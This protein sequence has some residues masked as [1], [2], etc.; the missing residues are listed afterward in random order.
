MKQGNVYTVLFAAAVCGV[1]SIAVCVSSV[2][3]KDL[4]EQNKIIDRQKNV[5]RVAGL[6]SEKEELDPDQV[7]A[8]FNKNIEARVL[9]LESGEY[10]SS[11]DV[12]TYDQRKALSDPNMSRP[13]PENPARII[14]LPNYALI[15][16]V[17]EK[18]Q[19]KSIVLPMEGKGLWSTMY[20][21][22]ALA[23]NTNT[24]LGITFYE[25][26]ETPGLGGE[27]DNP[28]WKKLWVGRRAFD[29][30]W[31]PKISVIKGLA[32]KPEIDPYRVDGISGATLTARGVSDLVQFWLG[33]HGFG[34]FLKKFRAKGGV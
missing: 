5:L 10:V 30:T 20:G 17:K 12:L 7:K 25:H 16:L 14:R 2:S 11:V 28:N 31:K 32:G 23:R 19:I 34:P 8:L 27:V 3:L 13:A 6:V 4:Q 24:I 9:D 1:F 29:D 26:G 21:Y 22:L 15:Y 18:D 33:D